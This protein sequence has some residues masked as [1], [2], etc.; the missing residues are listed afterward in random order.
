MAP[1][2]VSGVKMYKLVAPAGAWGAAVLLAAAGLGGAAQKGPPGPK[3]LPYD[4]AVRK[5]LADRAAELERDVL[6]GIRSG[7]AFEK[8][9]PGLRD[10][11]LDML[12]LK[13]LPERTP[14][15]AVVTGRLDRDGYAVEKLHFQ[16]RPGLYVTASLYLP[17]PAPKKPCPAIL[18]LCGHASQ[19]KREG[20]KAAPESQSHGIWFA[21]H[22]YV[23]LVLDTLE[24]GEIAA[25][26]RGT[27]QRERWWWY[28]AGYTPAGV[29][30]WNAIRAL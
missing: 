17:R 26:H 10:E 16:S 8:V 22:G 20:N 3:E 4:R 1:V 6:L 27:L 18:Y 12:G 2:T 23:A 15:K 11:Y 19:M 14:L 5:Y 13:P 7:A 9:R 21:T 29:E 30:C 24:L 28:S 25:V